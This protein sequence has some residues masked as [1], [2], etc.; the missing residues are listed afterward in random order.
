MPLTLPSLRCLAWVILGLAAA[1]VFGQEENPL[2]RLFDTAAHS[3]APLSNE[4]AT[5]RSGWQLVPEDTI[6][7]PFAGDAALLNDKLL[8][9][10]RKQAPGAE[11]YAKT[12]AGFKHRATIG[13]LIV[14]STLSDLLTDYKII[15]NSAGAVTVDAIFAGAA[16][17]ALRFRITTGEAILEIRPGPGAGALNIE[18]AT[19]YV[20]VPDYFGDDLVFGKESFRERGLP[21]ENFCLNLLAGGEA[22]IMSVW[23]AAGQPVWLGPAASQEPAGRQEQMSNRV[24]CRDGKSI[25][26]AFIESPGLWRSGAPMDQVAPPFP[27][28]WR[29]SFVRRN[30]LAD[31][32]DMERGPNPGQTT[33]SHAGPLLVYPI[34]RTDTTPLTAICP[35]DVMRNTLGV[36]PC[37]YILAVEGLSAEGDPTPNN[38]MEWVEKEFEQKKEKKAADEI[39]ERLDLMV[40]HVAEA[41]MRIEAYGAFA[42]KARGL[43]AGQPGAANYLAIVDDLSRFVDAGLV[44]E[45]SPER[46]RQA[47]SAVCT[48]VG[49]G[50]A[51]ADC[52]DLGKQLRAIGAI[53]DSALARC[54]MAVRRLNQEG[55][56]YGAGQPQKNG[57]AREVQRLAEKMLQTKPAASTPEGGSR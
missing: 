22:M 30:G 2:A 7:H 16:P 17:A 40:S 38:V 21:A 46:A 50:N 53:Q 27:A 32:W 49:R 47:A 44:P 11:V 42:R 20:V 57:Q 31:S 41:R 14:R 1:P 36:G 18:S 34:D 55:R 52:R 26:L 39:K 10:L 48:L 19:S 15:E 54:R 8:I 9:V 33:G 25:W 51:V 28:K 4:A 23:Q 12:P 13:N 5:R 43:L 24:G 56:S 45:A 29:C 37:Q 35:T 3:A 6:N